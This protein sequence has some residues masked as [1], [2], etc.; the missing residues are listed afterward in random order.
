MFNCP[1]THIGGVDV[2]SHSFLRLALEVSDQLHA[3]A[4][5]PQR[6]A[7]ATHQGKAERIGVFWEMNETSYLYWESNLKRS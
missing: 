2:K 1:S 3:P 6:T 7:I 4:D 5:F